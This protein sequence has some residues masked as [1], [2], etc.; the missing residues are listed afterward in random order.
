MLRFAPMSM[1]TIARC[2]GFA[3]AILLLSGGAQ[4]NGRYPRAQ[5]LV[6]DPNDPNRLALAATFGLVVTSDRGRNWY[7]VCEAAF[8]RQPAYNGDPLLAVIPGGPFLVDVQSSLSVSPDQG[9][10]WSSTLVGTN[11]TIADFTLSRTNPNLVVAAVTTFQGATPQSVLQ[12]ST[13][14][15]GTWTTLGSPIPAPLVYTVDLDPTDATHVFATAL[16]SGGAGAFLRSTD[17]GMT[18][19]TVL[20]PNTNTDEPP[21]IAAVHPTDPNKIFVRTD[22]WTNDPTPIGNDALLYSSDGGQTWR[23]VLRKNAKM[24]G[25][26]LSPDGTTVLAGYG[27]PAE[28]ERTVYSDALGIYVASTSDFS[29]SRI[30][31]NSVTCLTW[32]KTGLYACTSAMD[33]G[34]E[35][36]FAPDANLTRCPLTPL[37]RLTDVRGNI[38]GCSAAAVCDF[39]T[40]CALFQCSDAGSDAAGPTAAC[41]VDA[42]RSGGGGTGGAGGASGAAGGGGSTSSGGAGGRGNADASLPGS[43][44]A[45]APPAASSDGGG[46]SF[47]FG[48]GTRAAALLMTGFLAALIGLAR[49]RRAN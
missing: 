40:A 27:N 18:W 13:D 46:C 22:A 9:C 49:G 7:H 36:G 35:L 32:T 28:G 20:I 14:G 38:P 30:F 3:A 45:P 31:T 37:L 19:S 6:E 23:E 5:R 10:Q 33:S 26:A 8:S 39:A 21:Y 11:Q 25:F 12:Q 1:N 44:A 34:Y 17:Q 16:T 24:Y 43:D 15:G 41:L 4:A 2:F 29:F 47:G 48:R 42:G